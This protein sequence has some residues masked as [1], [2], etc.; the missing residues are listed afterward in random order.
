ML[1]P[2]S[3]SFEHEVNTERDWSASAVAEVDADTDQP[4]HTQ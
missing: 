2:V 3:T 4:R 1:L